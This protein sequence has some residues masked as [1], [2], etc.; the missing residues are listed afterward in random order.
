MARLTSKRALVGLAL[1]IALGASA[2][3]AAVL[4]SSSSAAAKKGYKVFL[5]PKFL[6]IAPFTQSNQG[7]QEAA[8]S[9]G[10]K[11]TYNGPPKADVA[12]QIQ[13]I[14]NAVQQHF[15]GIIISGNDPNALAPALKRAAQK[16]TKVVSF[17]ADVAPDARTVF[18]RPASAQGIG[19]IEVKILGQQIGY[20]GD[21]AILTATP[22]S[23]NQNTWI[24]FMKKLLAT[25]KYKGMH[26]V[27]IA[28]GQDDP[29]KSTEEAQSL[30]TSYPNLRGIIAPTS[31]GLP[32]AARVVQQAN[33]CKQVVVTGLGG[34]NDMRAF[35]KGGCVK[36]F[37][38]W[39]FIDL[40]YL[41]EQ[42]MHAV[43]TGKLTGKPGESF[44]A[45]RLGKK[46]IEPGS[47]VTIGL[48]L[49]FNKANI[50]KYHF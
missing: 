41:A 24:S 2:A 18:A 29:T 12:A 34:P 7:A 45:G 22:T 8:K 13:F 47:I 17:D 4:T 44:T 28:Y 6:G 35:V 36:A 9:L 15:N 37:A 11:V 43:L 39:S 32:A 40:G 25:P 19:E 33:K 14:N 20:K 46:T 49:V 48:P 50:D 23:S 16:G 26:L 38:L 42:T 31:V 1:A 5:L 21:I 3:S 27:K 10:D 30:L